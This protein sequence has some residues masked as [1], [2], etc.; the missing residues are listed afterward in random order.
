MSLGGKPYQHNPRQ[1]IEGAGVYCFLPYDRL[2]IKGKAVFKIGMSTNFHK[3][4]GGYH[5]SLPQ[6]VWLVNF[7]KNPTRL[8]GPNKGKLNL[9][10]TVIEREIFQDIVNHGGKAVSMDYRVKNQGRT[11]WVYTDVQTIDDAF[12]RAQ[13]KYGGVDVP[14]NLEEELPNAAIKQPCFIGETYF[15]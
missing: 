4:A 11:E 9:Y 6:G 7:L 15:Y 10:Y 2:D 12:E 14:V 13:H 3:R 5:T 8:M 1:E